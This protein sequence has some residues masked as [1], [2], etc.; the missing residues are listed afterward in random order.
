MKQDLVCSACLMLVI[1]CGPAGSPAVAGAQNPV[2][3]RRPPNI[4]FIFSDDHAYQGI[5]TIM[6]RA[7]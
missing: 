2:A 4:L 3:A 1:A 5:S 6:T 7:G